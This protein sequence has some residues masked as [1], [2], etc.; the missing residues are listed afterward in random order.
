MSFKKEP[1]PVL[2]ASV[3]YAQPPE[4]IDLADLCESNPNM[5]RIQIRHLAPGCKRPEMVAHS[6][7][8]WWLGPGLNDFDEHLIQACRH[9]KRKFQQA[10]SIADAKTYINMLR[11]SDWGNFALRCEEA[12]ALRQR[13]AKSTRTK[14]STKRA[15]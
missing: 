15:A 2:S 3:R 1:E 5:V 12:E 11:N 9:R 8:H 4:T 10:D 13:T 6:I 7:G 14:S